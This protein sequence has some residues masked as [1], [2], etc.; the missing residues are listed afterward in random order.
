[1]P[2]PS[3]DIARSQAVNA[4]RKATKAGPAKKRKPRYG[5]NE[6]VSGAV[7]QRSGGRLAALE[8]AGIKVKGVDGKDGYTGREARLIKAARAKQK[9]SK[10]TFSV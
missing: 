1:M 6:E 5:R 2:A 4:Y 9:G 7:A 3:P 8:K 10:K